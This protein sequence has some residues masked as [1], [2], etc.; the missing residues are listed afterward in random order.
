MSASVF[1]SQNLVGLKE[2]KVGER[3]RF[4][5]PKLLLSLSAEL[6]VSS[7]VRSVGSTALHVLRL[8]S[9]WLWLQ[10]QSSSWCQAHPSDSSDRGRGVQ[11][12]FLSFGI[13]WGHN[14]DKQAPLAG[15]VEPCQNIHVCVGEVMADSKWREWAGEAGDSPSEGAAHQGNTTFCLRSGK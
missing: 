8:S 2:K 5:P 15:E 1:T 7:G 4:V 14:L 13:T 11:S 6:G 12:H 9:W 3:Q 10:Q